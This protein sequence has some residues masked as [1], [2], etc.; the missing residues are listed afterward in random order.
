MSIK[1]PEAKVKDFVKAFMFNNF[2]GI[3][4]YAP[5]GGIFGKAGMPDHLY[6]WRSVLIA[7]EVKSPNGTL[8]KLQRKTLDDLKDQGAV[9]AV[10]FGKDTSKMNLIK[11]IIENEVIRRESIS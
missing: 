2:K 10:V 7:I 8:T 5:P 6:L 3:F 11:S 1:T 9:A 4:Y